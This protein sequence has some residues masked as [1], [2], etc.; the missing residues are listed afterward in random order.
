MLQTAP[1]TPTTELAAS[2]TDRAL[3]FLRKTGVRGDSVEMELELWRALSTEL[4]RESHW[5]RR[6]PMAGQFAPDC[7]T[8]QVIRRAALEVA[9]A[10]APVGVA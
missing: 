4:E 9:A 6:S 8:S 2:L 1:N 7:V 3:D 5:Q 10:F